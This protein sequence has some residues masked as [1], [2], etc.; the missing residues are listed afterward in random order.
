[1]IWI[2]Q[3]CRRDFSAIYIRPYGLGGVPCS[4]P[5]PSGCFTAATTGQSSLKQFKSRRCASCPL[6]TA[7]TKIYD[8]LPC[9]ILDSRRS[10]YVL[11]ACSWHCLKCL[12]LFCRAEA[13]YRKSSRCDSDFKVTECPMPMPAV[14]LRVRQFR[15]DRV[16][17]RRA[18]AFET[19]LV[20]FGLSAELYNRVAWHAQ[21]C[22][23]LQ[24]AICHFSASWGR[25][26]L[27]SHQDIASVI[28]ST[29]N[30]RLFSRLRTLN[31]IPKLY[32]AQPL[33]H[34]ML[35]A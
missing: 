16:D 13:R 18:T 24:H 2:R 17:I 35:A 23:R 22:L 9:S 27:Y 14:N 26:C 7:F 12:L 33:A 21:Q 28:S 4:A 25:H 30:L 11:R 6:A 20:F 8:G 29:Q 1:L 5:C 31:A 34:C 32:R 3:A 19:G 10:R 15:L